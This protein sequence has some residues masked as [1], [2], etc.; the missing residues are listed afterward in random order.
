M[1]K[2]KMWSARSLWHSCRSSSASSFHIRLRPVRNFVPRERHSLCVCVSRNSAET[3]TK[4]VWWCV[5]GRKQY[6][7]MDLFRS[8]LLNFLTWK[9]L[10]IGWPLLNSLDIL[11]PLIDIFSVLLV[12]PIFYFNLGIRLVPDY[13]L[14]E[15]ISSFFLGSVET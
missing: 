13:F 10:K 9:N 4:S 12:P 11:L 14:K 5:K 6:Y 1:E 8:Y 2:G 7:G 3:Q 15:L